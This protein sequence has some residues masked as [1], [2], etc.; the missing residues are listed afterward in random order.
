[1]DG[2][3]ACGQRHWD[4]QWSS[5]WGHEPFEKCAE[6]GGADACGRRHRG[7]SVELPNGTT[8]RVR[9]VPKLVARTH[10]NP[11]TGTRG[12]APYG[13]TNRVRGVPK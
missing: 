3:D 13:A 10:A 9:G 1:M 2:A 8:K 6:M 7:P 4:L 5:L 11:A 12:E